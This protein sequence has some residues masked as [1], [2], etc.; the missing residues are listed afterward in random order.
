[1]KNL[2]G[3]D[4]TRPAPWPSPAEPSS[5]LELVM[6]FAP[7]APPK[8]HRW[9]SPTMKQ[10]LVG[11]P[12]VRKLFD[13]APYN[14]HD[15]LCAVTTILYRFSLTK[16]YDVDQWWKREKIR[17]YHTEFSEL[18]NHACCVPSILQ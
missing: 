6:W 10:L 7:L 3:D 12:E 13:H 4:L 9:L 11:A 8:H 18:E 5:R 14:D 16:E 1:M 17:V 2:P 15:Q